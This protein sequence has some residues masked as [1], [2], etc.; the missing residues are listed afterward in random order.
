M[1][2]LEESSVGEHHSESGE[3][4]ECPECGSTNTHETGG[5]MFNPRR[6]L[7]EGGRAGCRDCGWWTEI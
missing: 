5:S 2:D 7:V 6:G 4:F 3:Q 1:S